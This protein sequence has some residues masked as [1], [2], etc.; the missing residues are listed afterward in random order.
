MNCVRSTP[1][2]PDP[3]I[4][5][6]TAPSIARVARSIERFGFCNPVL[7]DDDDGIIAGHGRIRAAMQLGSHPL[8][9]HD[10][11]RNPR[12]LPY[13]MATVVTLRFSP[14]TPSPEEL[15]T[16]TA[17]LIPGNLEDLWERVKCM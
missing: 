4:R 8:N 2:V 7:I 10:G 14:F 1:C 9:R 16:G 15:L 3:T 12:L 6:P 11:G 17:A 13:S 5:A